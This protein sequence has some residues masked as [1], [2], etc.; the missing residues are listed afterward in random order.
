MNESLADVQTVVWK[1][2]AEFVRQRSTV[3]SM[4]F[5]LAVFGVF[6]PLQH[7][8]GWMAS[9]APLINA[10]IFPIMLV[11]GVVAD[12]FA[13]EKERH[14]LETLLAS[15]LSDRAILFGKYVAV[16]V[17]S[18]GLTTA[19]LLVAALVLNRPRGGGFDPTFYQARTFM[20]AMTFSL[21]GSATAASVGVLVSLRASTVR[22][23]AQILSVGLMAF[24]FAAFTIGAML[25]SEWKDINTVLLTIATV[26]FHRTRLILD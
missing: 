14:T 2:W 7:G 20:A 19:S 15:R 24:F 1:E 8:R 13:G 11:M 9:S 16:V 5:F 6:L 12:A 25:P 22:Q 23:A 17:Y 4:L 26:R 18:W 10:V 21:L 3:V